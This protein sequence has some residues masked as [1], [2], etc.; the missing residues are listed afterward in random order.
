M[1]IPLVGLL[2]LMLK[3][4][5]TKPHWWR[6][7]K[8]NLSPPETRTIPS[9]PHLELNVERSKQGHWEPFSWIKPSVRSSAHKR[10][11]SG[12]PGWDL[13]LFV[14]P[15]LS[16]NKH[17][18]LCVTLKLSSVRPTPVRTAARQPGFALRTF[19]VLFAFKIWIEGTEATE[20]YH[21]SW[22]LLCVS[23]SRCFR[24]S[25]DRETIRYCRKLYIS[26]RWEPFLWIGIWILWYP[27]VH[28]LSI[29]QL[30][31]NTSGRGE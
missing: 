3:R 20:T 10:F 9:H 30:L 11:P 14:S 26:F 15:S 17:P 6:R 22:V 2:N 31:S 25:D 4:P 19:L 13:C 1:K 5:N 27:L 23:I 21:P 24:R 16:E 18:R 8:L 29:P 7:G 28:T 12:T